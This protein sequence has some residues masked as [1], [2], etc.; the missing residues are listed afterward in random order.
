MPISMKQS[1]HR[2]FVLSIKQFY[3]KKYFLNIDL[4][5]YIY[6]HIS[7]HTYI[8]VVDQTCGETSVIKYY[9]K[10]VSALEIYLLYNL[11]IYI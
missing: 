2:V 8:N 11:Y 4:Y 7:I 1:L 9:K 10:I 6:T 5:I 3:V